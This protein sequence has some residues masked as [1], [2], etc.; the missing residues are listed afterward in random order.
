MG[1][2][3]RVERNCQR[4]CCAVSRPV[5]THSHGS[6]GPLFSSCLFPRG[7]HHWRSTERI[8]SPAHPFRSYP[9]AV[10]AAA[11]AVAAAAPA[12]SSPEDRRS[13]RFGITVRAQ[14]STRPRAVHAL[15]AL[16]SVE[17]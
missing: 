15:S 6:R 17:R 5:V 4:H 12:S 7:P 3:Q 13:S 8:A 9:A 10:A 16:L 14:T 11:A 1:P 2:S